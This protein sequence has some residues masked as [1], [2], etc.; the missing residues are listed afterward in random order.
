MAVP[1]C[2]SLYSSLLANPSTFVPLCATHLFA[3][4]L[5]KKFLCLS[6]PLS[7]SLQRDACASFGSCWVRFCSSALRHLWLYHRQV[8]SL[9]EGKLE[10]TERVQQSEITR[11][12]AS[13]TLQFEQNVSQQ[14]LSQR[15]VFALT[16]WIHDVNDPTHAPQLARL[17]QSFVENNQN[18]LYVTAVNKQAGKGQSAAAGRFSR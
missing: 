2:H 10:D 12:L 11:S 14:L 18:I 16:G 13:E 17:L 15:Q 6:K 1:K 3:S 4:I 5:W 8:L 7:S 9:S